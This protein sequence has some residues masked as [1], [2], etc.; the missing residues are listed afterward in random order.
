MKHTEST[1]NYLKTILILSERN[2]YVRSI[3]IVRE[4]SF[5]K[6]SVSAAM[7]SFREKDYINVDDDG[8][9]TLTPSGLKIAE[10]VYERYLI[11]SAALIALGVDE[12]TA[13]EDSCRLEHSLSE[14]SFD[15]IK[16]H[17]ENQK[18]PSSHSRD[19]DVVLL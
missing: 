2:G 4:L 16:R 1:E 5:S 11:L 12:E 15:K 18:T 7:K 13:F 19:I 9:I 6:P 8:K 10:E 17:F 14:K 3:D